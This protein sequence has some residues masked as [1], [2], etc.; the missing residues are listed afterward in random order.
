MYWLQ[1][2]FADVLAYQYLSFQ[3]QILSLMSV[4]STCLLW[5]KQAV[6]KYGVIIRTLYNLPN[7]GLRCK[8]FN[9][10][11]ME[12]LHMAL[13]RKLFSIDIY[14]SLAVNLREYSISPSLFLSSSSRKPIQC[15][16]FMQKVPS[17]NVLECLW[18]IIYPP[19]AGD[20]CYFC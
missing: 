19:T 16:F 8:Y 5:E 3:W 14:L 11:F 4:H 7:M 13:C 1:C 12:L 2:M 17:D 6:L 20:A 15:R 10:S 18:A 9:A